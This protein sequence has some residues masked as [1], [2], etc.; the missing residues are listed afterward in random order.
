[1]KHNMTIEQILIGTVIFLL[2]FSIDKDYPKGK[3]VRK[4][5]I[6]AT[7]KQLSIFR[8]IDPYYYLRIVNEGSK[9]LAEARDKLASDTGKDPKELRITPSDLIMKLMYKDEKILEPFGYDKKDIDDLHKVYENS[10]LGFTTLMF[11]NRLLSIIKDR[12]IEIEARKDEPL[13]EEEAPALA[14]ARKVVK[15][16]KLSTKFSFSPAATTALKE[17]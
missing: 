9:V 12:A 17:V 16:S 13:T 5:L 7:K 2:L 1:M 15:E 3:R 4:K 14:E 8:K 11:I 10:Q 6:R